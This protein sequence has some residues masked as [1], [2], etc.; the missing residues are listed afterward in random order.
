[1]SEKMKYSA[2][3]L[4]EFEELCRESGIEYQIVW[5]PEDFG[6]GAAL[7]TEGCRKFLQVVRE[8]A[9]PQR[10]VECWDNNERY[11]D[12]TIRYVATDTLCYN[13]L[14][15]MDYEQHG[16]FVEINVIRK[17]A[18]S[19][20]EKLQANV[21]RGI[22]L[23][24][25]NF[26]QP[27]PRKTDGR[28]LQILKAESLRAGGPAKL[29]RKTFAQILHGPVIRPGSKEADSFKAKEYPADYGENCIISERVDSRSYFK[30]NA[31]L[32]E[33]I[34]KQELKTARAAKAELD[35]MRRQN[36]PNFK[37]ARETW[38]TLCRIDEEIREE[39]EGV[40]KA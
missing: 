32:L 10:A 11:P 25:H 30:E 39:Q 27:A 13:T 9:A 34:E 21:E 23:G 36:A 22:L 14:D 2:R 7:S 33:T 16:I 4:Q 1:M 6:S 12:A 19:L 35:Q 8:T 28:A 18:G 24:A 31:G 20:K 29:R 15:Y 26:R 40:D 5:G 37:V 3:L 17:K 38:E